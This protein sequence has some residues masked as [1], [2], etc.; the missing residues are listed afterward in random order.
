MREIRDDLFNLFVGAM[1]MTGIATWVVVI[2]GFIDA[3]LGK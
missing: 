3:V 1:T 2:N